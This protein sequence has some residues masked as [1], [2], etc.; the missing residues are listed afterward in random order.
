MTFKEK[1]LQQHL[2]KN[3]KFAKPS[4]IK[5]KFECH[6]VLGHYAG[7]VGYNIVDWLNKNKD[8]LNTSVVGIMQKSGLKVLVDCWSDYISPD[9]ANTGGGGGKKGDRNFN[10]ENISVN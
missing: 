4:N 2:G 7:D 3:H 5:R 6:F 8:P 9:D 10:V 1:L